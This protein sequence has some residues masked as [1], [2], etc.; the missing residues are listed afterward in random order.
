VA[1]AGVPGAITIATNMAGRGT[2]IQLG[3]NADMRVRQELQDVPE[4]AERERRVAQI[5]EQVTRL[6]QTALAAGG[7]YVLGTER[8]ESRRIDNQLRGRS[9][10]QGDPGHSKFFLA[11]E[12][13]LM[14][15]FGSDKL[16][17]MLQRLG[18]KEDEAIVHSWIN[19]AVEKA[20]QKVEARNFDIRKNLLKFDNVM[21]DQRK[22]IFDQRVELMRDET[23]AETVTDMRHEVIDE[24]LRKH[25]PENAY[26][27]QW[28]TAGLKEELKR[29]LSLD[30]PVDEWGKEEGIADEE[31][32]TR[33]ER[34]ADEHMA[35]K[36]AQWG[37][38]VIRYV[39]KSI[40]LQSLDHLWREHLV[41]L[42][43][44]RQ[45]IGLRGYGQR[46]PLNEYK[47]ESFNLFEAMVANLREAVT[48]QLMRVE[49]VQS[50]PPA[51]ATEL[52]FMQA[53][54][55]DPSTGEDE[56]ALADAPLVPAMACNGTSRAPQ[57]NPNDP[58][59]WGKVGRNEACPCGS[60]KKYKHCHGKYA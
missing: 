32:L 1:Q 9:G 4:G 60:G 7:L 49:I 15:I 39:E 42:E 31:M 27:E 5:K 24:L 51:E 50:P 12:D 23:V 30:L 10:R 19:K 46:D 2:D 18:L 58:T 37:T 21:N 44:L 35:A 43:H 34:R 26:P 56:L 20:Q 13:D 45:V 6:K 47:S 52:P 40:L 41:M 17:G 33:I 25:V 16:D 11:L 14:R 28:D 59:S 57:R 8:H 3:G 22:V 54:H 36:V 29:V 53:H 48:S 38:D 55:I